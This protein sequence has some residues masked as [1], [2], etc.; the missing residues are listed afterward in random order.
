[1]KT[2]ALNAT[3]VTGYQ[4]PVFILLLLGAL[5]GGMAMFLGVILVVLVLDFVVRVLYYTPAQPVLPKDGDVALITGASRGIGREIAIVLAKDHKFDVV[6]VARS[7]GEISALADQIRKKYS[8]KAYAIAS[9][10][11]NEA[12]IT[13]LIEKLKKGNLFVSLLVNNAGVADRSHFVNQS[14]K[15]IDLMMSLNV[16]GTT[17]MTKAFLPLMVERGYGRVLFVS[18]AI[19]ISG[20]P[21]QA[22]YSS[23]KA[24]V[25]TFC[26]SLRFELRNTGVRVSCLN[27]GA[28]ITSFAKESRIT[29]SLIFTLPTLQSKADVV[30]RAGVE[31][32]LN[33]QSWA[34]TGII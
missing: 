7:K 13:S 5:W 32:M 27:P 30:A 34:I 10:L 15:R 20:Q 33:G 31:T 8:V 19:G 14:K 29:S 17:M 25:S 26:S 2:I 28:T 1:M 12:G 16:I 24:Y 23:S 22:V 4:H 11:S 6:L 18:S 21:T 9:D 3:A